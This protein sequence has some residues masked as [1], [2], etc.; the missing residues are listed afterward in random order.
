MN[1]FFSYLRL[2]LLATSGMLLLC[3]IFAMNPELADGTLSG[4]I[5]W[6]HFT[7]LLLAG[8]VLLMEFT[9]KKSRFIFSLPDALLLLLFGIVLVSY[10]KDENLQPER[11]LFIAQ[12]VA[13]W[14]MLR[15]ALQAH[16]ELRP[17]FI[18]IIIFTGIV[19]AIWG[20]SHTIN[21]APITHPV[22]RLLETSL[23]P[24]PFYGYIA[25]IFPVCL[26]TL[27]RFKNCDKIA[28]WK[29]RTFLFYFSIL[30]STL[31]IT[32]LI[33]KTDQPVWLAALLSGIWVC[34]MRLIGWKQTKEA[35]QKHIQL[36]AIS[37]IILFVAITA[38]ILVGNIQKAQAGDRRLLI[39]NITTQ[40]I[41]E[42]PVTGI[43]IGGFPATYAK[44]QSA[45]FETD[46]ASSKEKQTAT[47]PQYAY[48]EYLQIGLELGITGL[49]FFIFWLAFSLY[50]GIR[51]RQIGTSGGIL[52]LGIFALYSYPLQLPTYWVLLLFLTAICVTNPKHDKQRAQRSIPYISAIAAILTCILFY[53][54]KDTYYTYREW[55]TLQELYHNQ[56][57]EQAASR[58]AGLFVQLYHRT[59]FLY[60]GAEYFYKTGQ[61][62]I[63][64]KWLDRAL[65]LS[66][67]PE[68]Y[69]AIAENEKAI[70][71]YRKA[72][73]YLLEISR[74]LPEQ[75]YTYFL[76]AKLY[77]NPSFL[78]PDKFHK[79]AKRFLAFQ[80]STQ[81]NITKEMKE[82]MLQI[83]RNSNFGK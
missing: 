71:Q 38:V 43:G 3:I 57:Y 78:H 46:T 62:D 63:A 28:L 52:A 47:C 44:E 59:D 27:L 22:F 35:I 21:P 72:E 12:L 76:L 70:K 73:S 19:P 77:T 33:F 51:H 30:G 8:G 10:D 80:P 37:S 65:K 82:E 53:G 13:L 6:F 74:I 20:I 9:T 81:N 83:I 29:S 14:F 18:T 75:G 16:Q 34:W 26:N 48:N 41:M 69:Y 7:S 61:H 58:Y 56:E 23:K 25:V 60:E 11:F 1:N 55:K 79:A 64:I 68:L 36:F 66:A 40:A 24:E 4:K 42:H 5:C 50:Y 39:W 17:F 31:I 2:L 15:G 45:Y 54:Q 67:A 49:L 32:T